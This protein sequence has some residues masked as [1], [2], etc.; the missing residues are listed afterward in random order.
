VATSATVQTPTVD[1]VNG[2]P[3]AFAAFA[4]CA[5]PRRAFMPASPT[6]DSTT[7][8]DIGWPNS[9]VSVESLETS[10]STR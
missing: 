9:S 4:A 1:S 3:A 2:T 10:R 5:S 8:I 7:G 6:G